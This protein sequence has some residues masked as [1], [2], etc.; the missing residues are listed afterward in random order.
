LQDLLA[1]LDAGPKAIP[2]QAM[3]PFWKEIMQFHETKLAGAVLIEPEPVRDHRG[4]FVRTF[5]HEEFATRGLETSFVQ[6]SLSR[7]T[8]SGTIRG[9]HFQAPPHAEVKLVR[10]SR[11]AVWDVIVDLRPESATY[12]QWQVFEL[13][14][15]NMLELYIPR[16]FAHGFQSLCDEAEVSYLISTFYAPASASGVRYDDDC[17]S[18]NWPRPALLMSERDRA[19]PD[20]RRRATPDVL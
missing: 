16:G 5:C 18:I 11:G 9:L 2:L 15:D 4:F 13:T 7:S 14:A 17:F 6:H 12:C 20:F 1:K 8:G 19:W 10:C 3:V